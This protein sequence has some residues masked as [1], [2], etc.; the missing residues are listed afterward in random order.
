MV[1]RQPN[2]L[3]V[4]ESGPLRRI[5]SDRTPDH[6]DM[7]STNHTR[8]TLDSGIGVARSYDRK[9]AQERSPGDRFFWIGWVRLAAATNSDL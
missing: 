9:R 7:A 3:L 4:M 6:R 2:C 1:R 5:E 8:H